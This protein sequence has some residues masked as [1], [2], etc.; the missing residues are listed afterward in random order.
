MN[1][2]STYLI[3][4][5]L[6]RVAC[7]GAKPPPSLRLPR[8][9]PTETNTNVESPA[10]ETHHR[11]DRKPCL[12]AGSL[13]AA[14]P[15]SPTGKPHCHPPLG[16]W[17]GSIDAMARRRMALTRDRR[18]LHILPRRGEMDKEE[19]EGPEQTGLGV[20]LHPTRPAN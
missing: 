9:L 11:P 1:R 17:I 5:K 12:T 13:A 4:G 14:K 20:R 6:R 16:S 10:G 2:L 15:H 3:P 8:P 7:C 19:R 18:P